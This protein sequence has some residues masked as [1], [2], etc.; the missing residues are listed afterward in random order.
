[1]TGV[2]CQQV[3][4]FKK[5]IKQDRQCMYNVT[6]GLIRATIVAVEKQYVSGILG[7]CM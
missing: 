4:Y 3:S 2:K 7:V 5:K 1:M 6:M